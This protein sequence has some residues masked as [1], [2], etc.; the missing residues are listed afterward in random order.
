MQIT[1]YTL[2]MLSIY[3]K[4]KLEDKKNIRYFF[5]GQ[6]IL[7][8]KNFFLEEIVKFLFFDCLIPILKHNI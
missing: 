6:I 4:S 8:E 5:N 3:I 1:C 2:S 7:C